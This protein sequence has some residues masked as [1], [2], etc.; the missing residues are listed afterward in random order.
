M[1]TQSSILVWRIPMDRGA[2]WATA[3]GVAKSWTWLS[4][5]RIF[6]SLCLIIQCCQGEDFPLCGIGSR[7]EPSAQLFSFFYRNWGKAMEWK[8]I[9]IATDMKWRKRKVHS[10]AETGAQE[11]FSGWSRGLIYKINPAPGSMWLTSQVCIL[12]VA[13]WRCW[14]CRL[15]EEP[16]ISNK[17]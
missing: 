6:L 14:F 15:E 9:R 3:H 1:A 17:T 11:I 10:K 16:Q 8:P 7:P 2:W 4:K 13:P 12:A 5:L